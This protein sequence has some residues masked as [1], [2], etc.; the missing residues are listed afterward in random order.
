MV[1]RLSSVDVTIQLANR[2]QQDV[3]TGSGFRIGKSNILV[4]N[5]SLSKGFLE[6]CENY[7]PCRFQKRTK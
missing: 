1:S 2:P 7:S 5:I 6:K 4:G 3:T